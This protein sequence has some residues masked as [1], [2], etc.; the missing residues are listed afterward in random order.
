M[1]QI[2]LYVEVSGHLVYLFSCTCGT[3]VRGWTWR[4]KPMTLG[5]ELVFPQSKPIESGPDPEYYIEKTRV[6]EVMLWT[7]D[8]NTTR[9]QKF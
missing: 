6:I 9:S 5:L 4:N 7:G 1:S 2:G 3:I 8:A